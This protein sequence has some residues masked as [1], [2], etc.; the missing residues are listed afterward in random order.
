M[1]LTD[2][3]HS[4]SLKLVTW[5]VWASQGSSAL[6]GRTEGQPTASRA[7]WRSNA[8]RH[9]Q[10]TRRGCCCCCRCCH[11]CR[12]RCHRCCW[13]RHSPSRQGEELHPPVVAA[14][15][16]AVA[17]VAV[18]VVVVAVAAVVAVVAVVVVV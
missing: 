11:C 8:P 2:R 14:A 4:H 6:V 16:V 3:P 12:C 7:P 13:Q 15:V 5:E 1:K 17:V 10:E 9:P 18:A